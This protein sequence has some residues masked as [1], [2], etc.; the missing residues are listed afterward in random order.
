MKNT[1]I[2][3]QHSGLK[4]EQDFNDIDINQIILDYMTKK[5]FNMFDE[6]GNGDIGKGEF[7]K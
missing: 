5:T 1:K 4:D 3:H 7:P 6:A 2:S